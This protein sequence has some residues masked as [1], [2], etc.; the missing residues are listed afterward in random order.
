VRSLLQEIDLLTDPL[1][2]SGTYLSK[3]NRI[4]KKFCYSDQMI[5]TEPINLY[6]L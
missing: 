5:V 2:N 1:S 4:L 3:S 6:D